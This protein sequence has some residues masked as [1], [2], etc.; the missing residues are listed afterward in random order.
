MTY[1]DM[2]YKVKEVENETIYCV[3]DVDTLITY[4]TNNIKRRTIENRE[5]CLDNINGYKNKRFTLLKKLVQDNLTLFV[6]IDTND[7]VYIMTKEELLDIK[8]NITN[9]RIANH[10]DT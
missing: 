10:L 3:V 6:V 7:K 2:I 4:K 1:T 9:I 5:D 8:N